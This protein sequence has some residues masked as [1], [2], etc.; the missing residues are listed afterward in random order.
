VNARPLAA[1]G[2]VTVVWGAT[3][4]QVKHALVGF[5][6]LAFLAWRFAI[7]AAALAPLGA[8]RLRGL[9][10][11][12]VAASSLAGVL[13][14]LGF[15]LQTAGL[16]HTSVSATGF[17]TGA[18]VVLTPLLAFGLFRA[19]IAR[20]SWLGALLT[21]A[22]LALLAGAQAGPPLGDLLVLAGA[23]VY[24]LQTVL[25]DRLNGRFDTRAFTFVEMCAAFAG[26][27]CIA[28]LSGQL[29]A[30]SGTRV[31][32]AL[33][34]TGIGCSALAFLAQT[35]AQQRLDATQTALA[36]SLEPVWTALF[37]VT[38]AGDQLSGSAILGCLV[39]LAGTAAAE[40][41]LIAAA[42][43]ALRKPAHRAQNT[44]AD[45]WIDAIEW[46]RAAVET[47]IAEPV[48]N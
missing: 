34:V 18:Y 5:P 10:L 16:Q 40:P 25:L 28:L 47:P 31:W 46:L 33:L 35:W 23:T 45:G 42:R 12:G 14:A 24:A 2:A 29:T 44:S 9:R 11:R 37:G 30:P 13:I 6:L 7:A 32:A 26:L 41:N 17:I 38:L 19:R 48:R 20:T 21:M 22:G 8:R 1:L 15:A 43:R 4:V 27:L 3:F 36:L 39:M